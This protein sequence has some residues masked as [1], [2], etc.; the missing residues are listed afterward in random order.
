M[1]KIG[2]FSS[3]TVSH[4]DYLPTL[5]SLLVVERGSERGPVIHSA[6]VPAFWGLG[7]EAEAE[8]APGQFQN[9]PSY[10]KFA[11]SSTGA[12]NVQSIMEE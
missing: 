7:E 8:E 1:R 11:N 2:W 10:L 9:L 5:V 4:L 12:Y 6:R 3:G